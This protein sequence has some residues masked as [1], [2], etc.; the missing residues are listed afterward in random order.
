VKTKGLSTTKAGERIRPT[1]RWSTRRSIWGKNRNQL[2]TLALCREMAQ[3]LQRRAFCSVR[4][5]GA[6]GVER[7]GNRARDWLALLGGGRLVRLFSWWRRW[8]H[9]PRPRAPRERRRLMEGA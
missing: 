9:E 5:D 4:G 2:D 8:G 7:Q 6:G 3:R 1:R